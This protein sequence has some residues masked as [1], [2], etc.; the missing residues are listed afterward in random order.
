M[1]LDAVLADRRHGWLGTERDKLT[2]FRE[3][4]RED[5]LNDYFY[6]LM[7]FG[8]GANATTRFFP[9]KLPV[10]VP[11]HCEHRHVF[12]YLATRENPM[13]FRVFLLR[14]GTLLPHMLEWTIRVL[15]PR[16]VRKASALY[17]YAL[18]DAFMN[19]VMPHEVE[20]LDWYFRVRRG[21]VV[22]PASDRHYELARIA[23][24]YSA[25][26]FEAL[27]RLWLERRY[28]AFW[29][30][31]YGGVRD[32]LLRGQARI[33]FAELPHQYLQLTPLV[34][35]PSGVEKGLFQGDDLATA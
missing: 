25:A 21:E 31:Q 11:L 15:L 5:K 28:R 10:G 33:E 23:R 14:H 2:Y 29:P 27:Y 7:T 13:A 12:L 24:E 20:E 30:V 19:R 9:D 18:R 34:G 1:L 26:R 35:A 16:R 22:F 17:R 4:L 32:Q 3:A 8:S 6:P